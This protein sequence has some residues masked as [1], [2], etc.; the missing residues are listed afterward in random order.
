MLG[1]PETERARVALPVVAVS[2]VTT[3]A[4]LFALT[5]RYGFERA[6]Q[7]ALP[8]LVILGLTL[9]IALGCA[10]HARARAGGHR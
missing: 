8:L 6:T 7:L 2:L 1:F 5:P 10:W 9:L 4:V 3:V